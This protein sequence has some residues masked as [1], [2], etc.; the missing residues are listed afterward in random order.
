MKAIF[1]R[2]I[3]IVRPSKK[4][5]PAYLNAYILS[6]YGHGLVLR[7]ETGGT[8]QSTLTC[9][10]LKGLD[11]PRLYNEDE[12]GGMVLQSEAVLNTA[13]SLYSSFLYWSF[14][15]LGHGQYVA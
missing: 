5:N 2:N 11:I 7:G 8:G 13:Q 1:S 9:S 15:C 4:I 10:Y 12:I 3:G 6:K 14:D